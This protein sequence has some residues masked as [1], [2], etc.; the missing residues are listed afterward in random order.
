MKPKNIQRNSNYM[1]VRRVLRS[2]ENMNQLSMAEK[3]IWQY[4]TIVSTSD[5][6]SAMDLQNIFE[7]KLSELTK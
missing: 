1:F 4:A 7:T 2:C 3:M 6:K 5:M